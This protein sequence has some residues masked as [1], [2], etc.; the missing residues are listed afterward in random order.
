MLQ[1]PIG[2]SGADST[3]LPGPK[4]VEG[5]SRSASGRVFESPDNLATYPPRAAV[6]VV[7][8]DSPIGKLRADPR[9]GQ[10]VFLYRALAF[11]GTT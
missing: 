11:I 10:D 8:S 9:R 2:P 5:C 1:P 6:W 4:G 3:C 7:R